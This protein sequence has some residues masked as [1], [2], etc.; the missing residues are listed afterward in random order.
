MNDLFFHP[1]LVHLPLALAVL[2]PLFAGALALA[3]WRGWLPRRTWWIAVAMQL[4]LLGSS[5]AALQ[6]GEADEDRVEAI[7]GDGPLEAHEEAAEQFTTA[8]AVTTVLMLVGG[9]LGGRL[10][11]IAVGLGLVGSLV[12]LGLGVRTGQRGGEL[13][14]VHGAASA[15]AAPDA[16]PRT[17]ADGDLDRE[18][19]EH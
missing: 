13:V 16:A 15:H 19:D 8:A 4:I 6:S 7:V 5:V 18:A 14:Y 3:W 17:P 1:K 10:A 2:V 12:G 9:L 11:P